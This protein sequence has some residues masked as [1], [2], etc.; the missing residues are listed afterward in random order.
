MR[1][2]DRCRKVVLVVLAVWIASM[3]PLLPV[4]VP[5]ASAQTPP[6]IK[7]TPTLPPDIGT[8][9][10]GYLPSISF[11]PLFVADAKGYFKDQGLQVE[12]QQFRSGPEAIPFLSTGA[13]DVSGAAIGS[14]LFNAVSQGLDVRMVATVS[15]EPPGYGAAP[16]LVRKDL[17]DTGQLTRPA[18]LKGRKVALAEVQGMAEYLTAETLA[19][20][21]L[22][23]DDVQVVF[24]PLPEM[25]AALAN[26]AVDAAMTSPPFW[27][28]AIEDGSAVILLKGDQIVDTPQLGALH[29]GRRLLDPANREAAVRFLVAYLKAAR[30]LYGDGWRRPENIAILSQY[31][32]LPARLIETPEHYYCDPNGQLNRASIESLQA[33]LTRRGYLE[34]PSPLALTQVISDTFLTEALERVGQFEPATQ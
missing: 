34:S 22:T 10:V 12:L 15:S 1:N 14:A 31:T 29:F 26:K 23:L 8:I 6:P 16:F 9:K 33:Y 25:P 32:K 4:A 13:L 20:G 5:A 28:K 19:R 2:R 21:G 17:F 30:D 18:D 27:S 11:A 7:P 3:A 24:L